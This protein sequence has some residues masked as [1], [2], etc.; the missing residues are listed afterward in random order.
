MLDVEIYQPWLQPATEAELQAQRCSASAVRQQLLQ[1][2]CEARQS[3]HS[4]AHGH[5]HS[6]GD[7]GEEHTH[8]ERSQARRWTWQGVSL[9]VCTPA[10]SRR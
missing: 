7:G 3:G 8:E 9:R 6:H 5:S 1:A 4:H 10:L 2:A